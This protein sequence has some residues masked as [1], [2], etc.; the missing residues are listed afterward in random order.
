MH[1]LP[2]SNSLSLSVQRAAAAF[3]YPSCSCCN[4]IMHLCT[5]KARTCLKGPLQRELS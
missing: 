3:K 5:F 2:K 4:Y 1:K